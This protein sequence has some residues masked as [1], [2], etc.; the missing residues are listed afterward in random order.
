M[1]ISQLLTLI[2]IGIFAG[3]TGG[4]LGLGGGVII[5]PSLVFIMG[6]SQHTAQGTSLAVLIFPVAL[7]GAYN[8]YRE[9]YVNV[10][11]VVILALAFFIG[12]YLGSLMSVNLSEKILRKIF[13]I[14][15][16]A[17]SIKMIFG[18]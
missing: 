8:Y 14:A 13:G 17:L 1:S 7:L 15:V 9:G 3:F 18:K 16:L 2:A 11:F 10:K 4:A 6:L 12:S 5:V